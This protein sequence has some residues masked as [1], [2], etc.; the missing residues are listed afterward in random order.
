MWHHLNDEGSIF[1]R[2]IIIN[3]CSRLFRI[4]KLILH[5]ELILFIGWSGWTLHSSYN[6][7]NQSNSVNRLTIEDIQHVVPDA[8]EMRRMKRNVDVP[9]LEREECISKMNVLRDRLISFSNEVIGETSNE[10][11]KYIIDS[12]VGRILTV[13][14]P[15]VTA[16]NETNEE[17]WQC[18]IHEI[19]EELAQTPDTIPDGQQ[20][21]AFSSLSADSKTKLRGILEFLA[22]MY[23]VQCKTLMAEIGERGDTTRNRT[24]ANLNKRDNCAQGLNADVPKVDRE[25]C[26][27]KINEIE[28]K[29]FAFLIEVI[30][31]TSVVNRSLIINTYSEKILGVSMPHLISKNE[32]TEEEWGII[33]HEID[34]ELARPPKR[35]PDGEQLPAFSSLSQVSKT[36]LRDILESIDLLYSGQCRTTIS[37]LASI[38]I[39]RWNLMSSDLIKRDNCVK[40][41]NVTHGDK[42]ECHG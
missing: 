5:I 21:P 35:N 29:L 27:S 16:A 30:G 11:N 19:D 4:L 23:N 3:N 1:Q 13:S 9:E 8:V 24:S 40:S 10:T 6:R 36:K 25:K 32:T 14:I 15:R 12:F 39:E 41:L 28:D 7:S 17:E 33:M 22:L 37:E 34:E 20:L 26:I 38:G 42:E 31:E 18:I 2:S